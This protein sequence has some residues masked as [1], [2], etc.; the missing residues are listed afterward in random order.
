VCELVSST[1]HARCS[2]AQGNP[3]PR[4]FRLF[5]EK[6]I[7]NRYGFNSD[8]VL[9]VTERLKQFRARQK[10]IVAAGVRNCGGVDRAH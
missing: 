3:K 6:A 1:H 9:P 5:E 7:I 8:G 2:L 4:V 10:Q